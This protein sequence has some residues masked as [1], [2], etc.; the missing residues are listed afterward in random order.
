MPRLAYHAIMIGRATD[1]I[2]RLGHEYRVDCADDTRPAAQAS[3]MPDA[4]RRFSDGGY[5]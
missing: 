3:P 1:A 4:G 2:V 5:A